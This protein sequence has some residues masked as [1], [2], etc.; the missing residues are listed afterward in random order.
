[1]KT[2]TK[3]SECKEFTCFSKHPS[4]KDG[5]K[6]SCKE[7]DKK[8]ARL[9]YQKNKE[10][11]LAEAKQHYAENAE[12]ALAQKKKH[13]IENK[14]R[15]LEYSNNRYHAKKEEIRQKQRIYAKNNRALFNAAG[16]KRKAVKIKA[17]PS[18]ADNE[19]ISSL[20]LLASM[21]REAGYDVH[22]DHIVPLQ[23]PYVCGLH[24]QTNLRLLKAVD[25]LSKSN[26]HW[27]DM[28]S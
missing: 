23:S 17:T 18:W 1:M 10:V 5:F 2:C 20:Y 3:C 22:V 13:Y 6:N 8:A 26:R 12:A 27:P 19:H 24:C 4:T 28:W 7:C 9:D 14:D 21:S 25:N 15:L 16:A 11:R